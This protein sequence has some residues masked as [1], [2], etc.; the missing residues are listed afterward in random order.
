MA[1]IGVIFNAVYEYD[2]MYLYA[3]SRFRI[4]SM[5]MAFYSIALFLLTFLL[6]WFFNIWGQ[7]VSISIV[8]LAAIL[9][10]YARKYHHF[11]F[12]INV[13][14]YLHII[15]IGLPLIVIGIAYTFLITIDRILITRFYNLTMLGYYGLAIMFF[16]FSQ[17]VPDAISQVTYPRLNLLLADCDESTTLIISQ[18]FRR[19]SCRQ[20]C[21]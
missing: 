9:F 11:S 20:R 4:A 5:A 19:C 15:K 13:T 14:V 3:H 12:R 8:P 7:L 16:V 1:S 17:Q 10:V 2:I 6:V 21:R 18:L